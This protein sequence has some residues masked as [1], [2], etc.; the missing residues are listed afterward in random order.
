MGTAQT[1]RYWHRGAGLGVRKVK[2]SRTR[3]E[4]RY[5]PCAASPSDF[6]GESEHE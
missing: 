3:L 4:G 5:L 2:Y 1:G 6:G